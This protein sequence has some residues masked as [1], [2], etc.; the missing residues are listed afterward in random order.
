MG[1]L[2]TIS[3]AYTL[4]ATLIVLPAALALKEKLGGAVAT[5]SK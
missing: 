5:Q 4:I 1:K 3:L 2:L